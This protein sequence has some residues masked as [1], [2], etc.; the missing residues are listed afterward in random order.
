MQKLFL[1]CESIPNSQM[2]RK[3]TKVNIT[4]NDALPFFE[5]N[6]TDVAKRYSKNSLHFVVNIEDSTSYSSDDI[7]LKNFS[8]FFF[9]SLPD[10]SKI[11]TLDRIEQT[12]VLL[13]VSQG[14][15]GNNIFVNIPFSFL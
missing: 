12:P 10:A 8:N 5:V 3:A 4:K 2:G 14:L 15:A 13:L 9:C 7:N 11:F 1:G 6:I